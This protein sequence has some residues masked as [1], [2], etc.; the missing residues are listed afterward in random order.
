MQG[1]LLIVES[2]IIE[3]PEILCND[4]LIRF[5]LAVKLNL[6]GRCVDDFV[7]KGC[8]AVHR[9]N[10]NKFS[11]MVTAVISS[12]PY[13]KSYQVKSRILVFMPW[14]HGRGT[15]AITEV[16]EIIR[17]LPARAVTIGYFIGIDIYKE[18]KIGPQVAIRNTHRDLHTNLIPTACFLIKY[19][20]ADIIDSGS[21]VFFHGTPFLQIRTIS[22]SPVP[23]GGILGGSV[24]EYDRKI[25]LI[26]K[27]FEVC[28]TE[29]RI[30]H[31]H[32]DLNAAECKT[33]RR[34]IIDGETD[35]IPPG[36]IIFMYRVFLT[37]EISVTELPEP[38]C[39]IG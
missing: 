17:R 6:I 34:I 19:E 28:K 39:C 10:L 26:N 15:Y 18:C 37:S 29:F 8:P 14:T 4:I 36:F 23:V 2:T 11:K 12:I 1:I 7:F 3:V 31:T 16:P 33:I 30:F 9:T 35:I 38:F 27:V 21:P 32:L 13:G 5:G 24:S 22:K 25:I 20:Q